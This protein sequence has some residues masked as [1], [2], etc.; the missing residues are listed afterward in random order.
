MKKDEQASDNVR[1]QHGRPSPFQ[2][3]GRPHKQP[4]AN[5]PA[6][7]D[8]FNMPGLQSTLELRFFS[9]IYPLVFAVFRV[10]PVIVIN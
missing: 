7:G 5:R 3:T 1:Q 8:Q 6:K 4:H 10:L 9:V 2:G